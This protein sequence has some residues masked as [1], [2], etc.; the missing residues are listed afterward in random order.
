LNRDRRDA[1]RNA[2]LQRVAGIAYLP[3]E[4]KKCQTRFSGNVTEKLQALFI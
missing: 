1:Q 3:S 2:Q 4:L